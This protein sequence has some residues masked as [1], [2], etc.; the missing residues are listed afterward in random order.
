MK[1]ETN[2]TVAKPTYALHYSL[3]S[4]CC[5]VTSLFCLKEQC[6]SKYNLPV[7]PKH[8]IYLP[9]CRKGAGCVYKVKEMVTLQRTPS[10][11]RFV[12][13]CIGLIGFKGLKTKL[14]SQ[15]DNEMVK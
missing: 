10:N 12:P 1:R 11:S 3:A 15:F 2:F 9:H 4:T 14:A 8:T 7:R 5:V 6:T 13:E